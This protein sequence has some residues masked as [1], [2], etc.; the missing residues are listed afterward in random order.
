MKNAHS[1]SAQNLP[2]IKIRD[3]SIE[4]ARRMG[5]NTKANKV[6]NKLGYESYA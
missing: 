3:E 4:A 2:P 6:L 1:A 5:A